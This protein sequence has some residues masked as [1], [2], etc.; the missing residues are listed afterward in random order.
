MKRNFTMSALYTA[1]LSNEYY[2]IGGVD[3]A[4]G[5]TT[6]SRELDPGRPR[7]FGLEARVRF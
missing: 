1:S 3:F 7:Q 2:L 4:G 6:G 5:Y